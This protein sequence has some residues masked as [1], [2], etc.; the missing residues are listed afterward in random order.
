LHLVGA[1]YDA[2]VGSEDAPPALCKP[3]PYKTKTESGAYFPI[4][5]IFVNQIVKNPQIFDEASAG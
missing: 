3:T 2:A 5:F 1:N 4:P